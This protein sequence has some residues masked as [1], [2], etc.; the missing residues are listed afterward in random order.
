V[1]DNEIVSTLL[2]LLERKKILVEPSGAAGFAAL[3]YHKV[4][5]KEDD[6]VAVLIT[7]GNIELSD[8]A[9]IIEKR[10]SA[11]EGERRYLWWLKICHR[12]YRILWTY[13]RSMGSFWNI[14][15]LIDIRASL[16]SVVVS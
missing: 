3:L 2:L 14:F 13:W 8:L 6:N 1:S 4:P 11:K 7:G 9:Y 15:A 10:A 5:V 16:R 12:S